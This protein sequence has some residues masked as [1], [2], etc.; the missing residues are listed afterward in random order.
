MKKLGRIISIGLGFGLVASA[1]SFVLSKPTA[2]AHGPVVTVASTP[3]P[4]SLAGTGNIKAVAATQSG[5]WNVGL[6][7]TPTVSF[8]NTSKT[9]LFVRDVDNPTR[10]AFQLT[11]S[12][13]TADSGSFSCNLGTVGTGT[14]IVIETVSGFLK[15][16]A[17]ISPGDP[18]LITTVNGSTA[19]HYLRGSSMGKI[20]GFD[21]WLFTEDVRLYADASTTITVSANTDAT[22]NT[23][24]GTF[25]LSGY[26]VAVL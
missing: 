23:G 22:G 2:A 16:P 25:T 1:L 9:P 12:S 10:A 5:T 4:V 20:A 13:T 6:T 26:T 18:H 24:T 14:R 3:R 21:S 11:C 15:V 19:N 8:S 7:G 17:G